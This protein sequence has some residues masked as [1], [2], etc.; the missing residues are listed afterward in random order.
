MLKIRAAQLDLAR[1]KETP[2]FIERFIDFISAHN[3]NTLGLYLE[4]SVRTP[5]FPYADKNKS[6]SADDMRR[7]VDYATKRNIDVIPVVSTLGHAELF[8]RHP[9]FAHLGELREG[10]CGRFYGKH[11][12][13][14]CPSLPET[15]AFLERYLTE[16]CEIFPSPYFHAG[17]DEVW[18][19][20]YC[21]LCRQ[22]LADGESRADIYIGHL[23]E[24]HKIISGKLGR[25]MIIWDDM[26]E[27]YPDVLEK[28]PRDVVLANWQYQSNVDK[29][30]GHFNNRA[31]T[32]A[33]ALYNKL[34]FE[35]LFCPLDENPASISSFT[36]YA[37]GHRPLGAWLTAW[38]KSDSLMFLHLPSY[39]YAARLWNGGN[40]GNECDCIENFA[41][42]VRE[43]FEI[44][45]P[46]FLHTISACYLAGVR[47]KII[48]PVA[49]LSVGE[50]GG[51]AERNGLIAAA[52]KILPQY[53][54]E[55]SHEAKD[56]LEEML[57]CLKSLNIKRLM[58]VIVPRFVERKAQ[59]CDNT[60]LQKLIGEILDLQSAHEDMWRKARPG[61]PC[62]HLVSGYRKAVEYLEQLP[63][64]STGHGFLKVHFM[65]PDQHSSQKTVISIRY[66]D[67]M[68]WEEVGSGV[69]KDLKDGD[70]FYYQLFH[71]D[72]DRIPDSLLIE[73]RGY[74]GQGFTWFELHNHQGEFIPGSITSS[75]GQVSDPVNMLTDDWRWAFAGFRDTARSFLHPELASVTHG[76]TIKLLS[77]NRS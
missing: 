66:A 14:F 16:I 12:S 10:V 56:V 42:A 48:S 54:P 69:F 50:H 25:R 2:E 68:E 36:C 70:C 75:A 29:P 43:L 37:Y 72:L 67:S 46:V 47:L 6:Y 39:A 53:L 30:C 15:L 8:L 9:Q 51:N 35:Y 65:L 58:D 33:F 59:A 55:V 61:M 18:D 32:D 60:A 22:R 73:T 77:A 74:G 31:K 76:F 44:N 52:L 13:V 57:L 1:Q 20:G 34:G 40:G 45:D 11:Q 64:H 17:C 23:L 63:A 19:V 49:S 24:S 3:F 5:S 4:A 41:A 26:F 7:I 27:L 21:S 71:I 28:L 38:E 62:E